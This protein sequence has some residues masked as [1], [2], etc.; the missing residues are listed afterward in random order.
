M[1]E[2]VKIWSRRAALCLALLVCGV[3]IAGGDLVIYGRDI[4]EAD[5]GGGDLLGAGKG[6]GLHFGSQARRYPF[7]SSAVTLKGV[8]T[9]TSDAG[10]LWVQ[11]LDASGNTQQDSV[12]I[13]GRTAQTFAGNCASVLAVQRAE[14]RDDSTNV[15]EV[16][17]FHGANHTVADSLLAQISPRQRQALMAQYTIPAGRTQLSI[18]SFEGNV[19]LVFSGFPSPKVG[20]NLMGHFIDS[21]AAGHIGLL[22][23][24]PG[25]AWEELRPLANFRIGGGANAPI[26]QMVT[27]ETYDL[28]PLT[29]LEVAA[30]VTGAATDMMVR[31]RIGVK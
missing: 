27:P 2:R 31:M 12:L 7:V 26:M 1:A 20:G 8:S 30:G 13:A 23:R 21:T 11:C 24:R 9:S 5:A 19:S 15:G 3:G 17:V 28:P 4:V 18:N 22:A 16:R 6:E 14:F 25:Q 10:Y 29:Q